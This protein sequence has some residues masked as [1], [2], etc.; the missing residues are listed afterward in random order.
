MI[1]CGAMP[2]ITYLTPDSYMIIH[3][4]LERVNIIYEGEEYSYYFV[5]KIKARAFY[6]DMFS[7]GFNARFI[8]SKA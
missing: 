3:P 6:I 5:D 8:S 4:T 1:F 7:K 2:K